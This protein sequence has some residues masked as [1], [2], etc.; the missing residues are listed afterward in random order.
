ME[1]NNYIDLHIHSNKSDGALST[2][3]IFEEAK[4]LNLKMISITDHDTQ[5]DFEVLQ[6]LVDEFD[7]LIYVPG[8]EISS[9]ITDRKS[10]N[11][12]IHILGYGGTQNSDLMNQ[13]LEYQKEVRTKVNQEYI[14]KLLINFPY[15]SEEL[16]S[17]VEC[18]QYFRL[19]REIIS[20]LNSS[21]LS[22]T[23][24]A[25][26]RKYCNKNHPV[27]KD[28]DVDS[29]ITI[30]AISKADGIPVLAHPMEYELRGIELKRVIKKLLDLGI[31]GIEAYYSQSS[32]EEM[33]YMRM[34]AES[35]K[36]L[37]SSGSDFHFHSNDSRIKILGSGIDNNLCMENTSL[38]DEIIKRSLQLKKGVKR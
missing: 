31:E 21:N 35:Y 8:I 2:R 23:Q 34:L 10:N 27:Y 28:Y 32:R 33:E 3:Q 30:E 7:S 1:N 18:S 26:I 6:S 29:R 36:V 19:A 14:G 12:P 37:Y 9:Y 5:N 38:S 11:I 4:N 20:K 13:I 22:Q 17:T 15:L 24:I 25:E 16:M